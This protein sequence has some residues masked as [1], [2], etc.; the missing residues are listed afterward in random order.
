[1]LRKLMVVAS[2]LFSFSAYSSEDLDA[3]KTLFQQNFNHL[4]VANQCGS[5]IKNFVALARSKNID[6]DSGWIVKVTNRGNTEIHQVPAMKAREAGAIIEDVYFQY[7]KKT[8]FGHRQIKEIPKHVRVR[9]AG[10]T[11]WVHYHSFFLFENHIFDFDFTNQPRVL[12][13]EAYVNEM[14]LP[15]DAGFL[16]RSRSQLPFLMRGLSFEDFIER[17]LDRDLKVELISPDR[18]EGGAVPSMS[19]RAFREY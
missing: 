5:N 8:S 9:E 10:P 12:T 3:L 4:Y 18:R 17:V 2:I 6:V 14:F 19:M 13:S 16:E 11:K 15:A 1:M 7:F